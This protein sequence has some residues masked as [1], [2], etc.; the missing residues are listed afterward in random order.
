MNI[1]PYIKGDEEQIVRLI[2]NTWRSAYDG[3]FPSEVFD[4]RDKSAEHRI[5]GF[6]DKLKNNDRFCFVAEEG[7]KIAGVMIASNKTDIDSFD[8]E[9]YAR[10]IALYIDEKF[11]RRGIGKQLFDAFVEEI[12]KAG[13]SKFVIGVLKEN[14]KAR[15]AY[16]KWGGKL[17]DYTEDFE[18]AGV[19]R[20][21]VFYEYNTE[22]IEF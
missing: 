14:N 11:Q 18:I 3:I 4:A 12:E 15:I 16:E 1:R 9:N 17:T 10:I 13:Q 22:D 19:S 20:K 8:N 2:N 6:E 5:S 21:E 7:L